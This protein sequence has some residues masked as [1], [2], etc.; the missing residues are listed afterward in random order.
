MAE[1]HKAKN[2]RFY[3]YTA[4]GRPR[5]ISDAEAAKHRG[6]RSSSKKS[7]SKKSSSKKSSAKASA[8]RGRRSSGHAAREAGLAKG[9]SMMAEAAKLYRAG[10]YDNMAKALKAVSKKRR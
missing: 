2:G 4:D 7:S 5:F 1:V 9:Q 3:I 6:G 8:T 10:K